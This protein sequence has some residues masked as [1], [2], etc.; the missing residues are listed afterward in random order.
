MGEALFYHDPLPMNTTTCRV[1]GQSVLPD[2]LSCPHCSAPRPARAEWNGEGY[3]WKSRTLWMGSPVLHIAFGIAP[4]GKMRTARGLIA[5]GQHAVG[6]LAIGII[7]KGF[8]AVGLVSFGVFSF[9][10]V[11][12]AAVAA[13]GM[14]ALAPIAW[15]VAAVGYQ[16]GGLAP[17]GVKILWSPAG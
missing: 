15:G 6:G 14:N 8:F 13:L 5:V 9:G 7:A 1:C 11:S 17:F 12:I 4:D 3:E 16:V 2:E 10:V